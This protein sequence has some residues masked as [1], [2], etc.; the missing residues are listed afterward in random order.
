VSEGWSY[1]LYGP[2]D[3]GRQNQIINAFDLNG[4]RI[5][6]CRKPELSDVHE[7]LLMLFQYDGSDCAREQS[8]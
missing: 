2:K 3:L 6:R 5:K 1:K 7:A 4:S 8:S